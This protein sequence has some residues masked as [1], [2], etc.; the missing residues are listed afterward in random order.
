MPGEDL[1]QTTDNLGRREGVLRQAGA[2]YDEWYLGLGRFDGLGSP[3]LGRRACVSW[4]TSIASLPPARTLDVACGTGFL[5]RHLRG[6]VTGLDQS[7]RMLAIARERMPAARFVCGDALDLPLPM[8]PSSASS[9]GTF[10]A[11]SRRPSATLFGRGTPGRA[12]DTGRRR[13]TPP[14]SASRG[15]TAAD[16]QRRIS[17]RSSS[18]T[19]QARVS[20]RSWAAARSLRGPLVRRGRILKARDRA[21]TD[22][23][24]D[25]ELPALP[26]FLLLSD[27][28]RGCRR[29]LVA[30]DVDRR[31]RQPVGAGP[32]ASC[33]SA[34]SPGWRRCCP[35]R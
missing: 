17:S 22:A 20:W 35:S 3:S 10:M 12:T 6:E 4:S 26:L 5:T 7:E 27:L 33:R 23:G 15:S 24:S 29:R 32:G 34:G 2:E 11:I 31:H 1:L 18:A 16:P 9:P 28:E 25:L 8:T 21:R 19:S 30:G 13:G 14:G